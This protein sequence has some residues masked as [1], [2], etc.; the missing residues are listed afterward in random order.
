M[1]VLFE[2]NS[3]SLFNILKDLNTFTEVLREC[4]IR[5]HPQ[6]G[7]VEELETC[8]ALHPP[9]FTICIDDS[10]SCH[11]SITLWYKETRVKYQ[12]NPKTVA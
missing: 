10:I 8:F 3:R 5:Q 11:M 4:H 6:I 1:K 7:I 12:T 9:Q 2:I